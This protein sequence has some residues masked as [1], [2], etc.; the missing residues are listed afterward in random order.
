[1]IVGHLQPPG[2]PTKPPTICSGTIWPECVPDLGMSLSVQCPGWASPCKNSNRV[3]HRCKA[4][5]SIWLL[6]RVKMRKDSSRTM[7]S[8][9]TP[10]AT[11]SSHRALSPSRVSQPLTGTLCTQELD[12][13]SPDTRAL[14]WSSP[15]Q[16]RGCPVC[17][18]EHFS[19]AFPHVS[20]SLSSPSSASSCGVGTCGLP[21]YGLVPPASS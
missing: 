21:S 5:R 3:Q 20:P 16:L 17:L 9:L 10:S 14:G 15:G 7:S 13:H 8:S 18:G 4:M 2:T 6:R 19:T 1:M 12:R 11:G